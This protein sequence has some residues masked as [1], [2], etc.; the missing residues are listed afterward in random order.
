MIGIDRIAGL[1]LIWRVTL[2]IHDRQLDTHEDEI[3]SLFCHCCK[4]LLAVL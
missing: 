2:A 1:A 3:G 4:R